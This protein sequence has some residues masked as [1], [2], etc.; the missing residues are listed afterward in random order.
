MPVPIE[1][2]SVP[3]FVRFQERYPMSYDKEDRYN[4]I[5]PRHA[6]NR[7]L[8]DEGREGCWKQAGYNPNHQSTRVEKIRVRSED[9]TLK[10]Y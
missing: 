8:G 3:R 10:P 5:N 7:Y 2:Y 1:E 4:E 6:A 9:I